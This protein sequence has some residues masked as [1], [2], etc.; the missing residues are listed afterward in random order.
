MNLVSSYVKALINLSKEEDIENEMKKD[1]NNFLFILDKNPEIGSFLKNLLH[2]YAEKVEF[3]DELSKFGFTNYFINFL[4]VLVKEKHQKYLIEILN[5]YNKQILKNNNIVYGVV[6]TTKAISKDKISELEKVFSS[7][8][9]QTIK[10][11][12][13]IDLNL[14]S[15]IK[16]VIGDMNYNYSINQKLKLIKEKLIQ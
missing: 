16:V 10:L 5:A 12:S 11:K 8:L 2:P 7:K 3:I 15:G 6:F 4:K 14:I 9:N 1:V 13:K